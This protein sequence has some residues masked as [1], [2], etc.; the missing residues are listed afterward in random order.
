M[1]G[2][3][4]F[5]G[6]EASCLDTILGFI[7]SRSGLVVETKLGGCNERP[8]VFLNGCCFFFWSSGQVFFDFGR[9]FF[10]GST[11]EDAEVK[12]IG[13]LFEIVLFFQP[14]CKVSASWCDPTT[15]GASVGEI[16]GLIEG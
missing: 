10:G 12:F 2:L 16:Q 15:N 7:G 11:G 5:W 1:V 4:F 9:F 8:H 6:W 14:F 13:E 3:R